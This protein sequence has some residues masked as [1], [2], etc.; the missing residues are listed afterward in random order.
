[1]TLDHNDS[2][3]DLMKSTQEWFAEYA[4]THSHPHNKLIHRIFVP[5][6]LLSLLGMLWHVRVAEPAQLGWLNG[7]VLAGLVA[8]AFYARL[9]LGPAAVMALIIGAMLGWIAVVERLGVPGLTLY[10]SIFVVSWIAQFVGH[11]I[12]G[13]KP[14]FFKDL[15]FLL[16]GPLWVSGYKPGRKTARS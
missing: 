12:E 6:I 4:L 2:N 16:I 10:I 11:Y 14:S 13:K 9:G 1:M 5:A 8:M 15:Q 7:G 3:L